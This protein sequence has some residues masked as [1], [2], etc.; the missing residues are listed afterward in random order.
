ML[1]IISIRSHAVAAFVIIRHT[2]R[3]IGYRIFGRY[4]AWRN[5][6]RRKQPL[7]FV[8]FIIPPG[9]FRTKSSQMNVRPM[10]ISNAFAHP[11]GARMVL[12]RGFI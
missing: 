2:L 3:N 8:R 4:G 6:Q 12:V 5:S 9:V 11:N 1:I 7:S 10:I